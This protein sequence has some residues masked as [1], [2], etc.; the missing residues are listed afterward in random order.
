MTETFRRGRSR[1]PGPSRHGRSRPGCRCRTGP[2]GLAR[3]EQG[4][5]LPREY[6]PADWPRREARRL[7]VEIHD[8]C[9]AAASEHVRSIVAKYD[10]DAA[11]AV[12]GLTVAEAT[13]LHRTPVAGRAPGADVT[14]SA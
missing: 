10:P 7:F 6:L 13:E 8:A 3:H 14:A 12:Q 11:A 5:V 2:S 1:M 9:V 4:G